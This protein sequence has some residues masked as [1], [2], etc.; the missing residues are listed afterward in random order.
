MLEEWLLR[1]V[2]GRRGDRRATATP[3]PRRA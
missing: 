2:V 1:L 3:A